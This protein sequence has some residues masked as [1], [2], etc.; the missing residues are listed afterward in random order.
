MAQF[1]E[2]VVNQWVLFLTL[3]VVVGVLI[4][5][6]FGNRIRGINDVPP[7]EAVRL[8][9]QEEAV[10][11]DVRENSEYAEGHILDAHHMPLGS[12]AKRADE[13]KKAGDRPL[14]VVCRS[15]KRSAFGCTT[16]RKQGYE[17]IYNL[18]G[19]MIAWQNANLPVSRERKEKSK[20]K[21]KGG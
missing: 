5:D 19:G 21:K 15:G 11:V 17:K 20:S 9:N 2:F 14:L 1:L 12:L 18:K 8:I 3:F 6:I 13:L 4:W 7:L 16:L 10:V